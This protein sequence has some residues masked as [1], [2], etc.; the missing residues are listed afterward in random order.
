VSAG[1]PLTISL[2]LRNEGERPLNAIR[3]RGPFLPWDGKWLAAQARIEGVEAGETLRCEARARF[4]QRGYHHLDPFECV[5]L[6]PFGLTVGPALAT[7]GCRVVVV[8]PLANVVSLRLTEGRS[9][10]P[11]GIANASHTGEALEVIGVRPYRPGDPVRDLHILTWARTGKPH[12]LEY[13]QEYFTRIGVVI[14]NDRAVCSEEGFE[15]AISLAAGVVAKLTSGEALIDLL[16]LGGQVHAFTIGR[17]LGTLDQ[18]LDLLACADLGDTLDTPQLMRRLEPYLARLSCIVLITQSTDETR[19]ALA[20]AIRQ[21]NVSC[22]VLRVHD[23][24][25]PA[26][27]A[28]RRPLIEARSRDEQVVHASRIAGREPLLL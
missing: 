8:P 9:Y 19:L 23:D 16:V 27:L 13:Q 26:W 2:T 3:I 5:A 15:A 4:V 22:S 6:V 1:V 14:D 28:K 17:A 18:A 12:V 25:G 24:S 21:R 7:G 11:G 10:Q 20:A